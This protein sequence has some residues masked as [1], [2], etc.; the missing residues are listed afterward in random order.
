MA[1]TLELETIH[2]LEEQ[3]THLAQEAYTAQQA[4][5]ANLAICMALEAIS[6]AKYEPSMS[7][8]YANFG[9]SAVM[10]GI[11]YHSD[12]HYLTLSMEEIERE[13]RGF[14]MRF[15]HFFRD[16][17]VKRVDD[18]Q[19]FLTLVD[20]QSG[21]LR[22]LKSELTRVANGATAEV[23]SPKSKFM[24][25]GDNEAVKTSEEYMKHFK[26]MH[27]V[28]IPMCQTAVKL[29]SSSAFNIPSY[30]VNKV[31]WN[32]DEFLRDHFNNCSEEVWHVMKSP[33]MK[34]IRKSDT[35]EVR[36]SDV[37]LGM[38]QV[39]A[40]APLQSLLKTRDIDEI[41]QLIPLNYVFVDRIHKFSTDLLNSKSDGLHFNKRQIEEL[42]KL[43][44]SL[45]DEARQ[46]ISF[47]A[48]FNSAVDSTMVGAFNVILMNPAAADGINSAA[49]ETRIDIT[50]GE[51]LP[52]IRT[53][54]RY[55][56]M[57][58]DCTS[59]SYNFA[60]GNIKKA[61]SIAETFIEKA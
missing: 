12:T 48:K 25:Y 3:H 52:S 11:G 14:W 6:H 42:L 45:L 27:S 20:F 34:L 40:K 41:Q 47:T 9:I 49:K 1:T 36:S 33:G 2:E 21:R 46:L 53:I 37:M 56:S 32:G 19:T 59:T 31:S 51:I 26:E 4:A 50:D 13:K 28:M 39:V 24:R 55:M 7:A 16:A 10:E 58:Y 29:N 57:C 8:N 30:V 22:K 43:C 38:S 61:L 15:L 23:R 18:M 17:V 35:A 54:G 5:D 60:M 44:E